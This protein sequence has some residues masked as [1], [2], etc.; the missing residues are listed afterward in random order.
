MV[1]SYELSLKGSQP[2]VIDSVGPN[3][4]ISGSTSAVKVTLSV[5]TS[6]GA[7][8]GKAICSFSSTGVQNALVPMFETNSYQHYQEL[9]LTNGTYSYQFRCV[10]AGGN[11]ATASTNFKVDVDTATPRVTRVYKDQALKIVTD[12]DAECR[13]SL[14]SCN[15][16]FDE[17]IR[18][19]YS[20]SEVKNQHFADWK[21]GTSY[22]VK[23]TDVYG[24]QPDP[25]GCSIVVRPTE[26]RKQAV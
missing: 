23:C 7:E 6:N 8:E 22:Y 9:S 21:P 3:S 24:N 11:V 20:N 10:D 4:T 15:F 14:N 25:S 12:E 5:L 19:A 26:L 16:N 13:Y 18:M 1:Q 2:L 17:G